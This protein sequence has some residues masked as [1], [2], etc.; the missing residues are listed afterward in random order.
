MGIITFMNTVKKFITNIRTSVISFFRGVPAGAVQAAQSRKTRYGGLSLISVAAVIGILVLLNMIVRN[1]GLRWDLT[2]NKLYS[3]SPESIRVLKDV[4]EETKA[5]VFISAS[6]PQLASQKEEIKRLLD[7]YASRNGKIKVEYVDPYRQQN[8]ATQYGITRQGTVVFVQGNRV[9]QTSNTT[10]QDFTASLIKLRNPNNTKVVFWT[11]NGEKDPEGMT[12]EGYSEV[13]ATLERLNYTVQKQ[14]IAKDATI[15]SDAGVIVLAGPRQP[16]VARHV[17][18]LTTY[19]ERGGRILVMFET[20]Q[21]FQNTGIE[22][23]LSKYGIA[24]KQGVAVDTEIYFENP[25]IPG[26]VSYP[27]HQITDKTTGKEAKDKARIVAIGDSDSGS[28]LVVQF[29]QGKQFVV[30]GNLDLIVNSINWLAA[31]EDLI[32]IV[33]KDRTQPTMSLSSQ[34]TQQ[35]QYFTLGILPGVFLL[36]AVFVWR[37]RKK[38]R[39]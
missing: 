24:V 38:L 23:L 36:L 12:D 14:D 3:L 29:S 10:E 27:Q 6:D 15:A 4:K 25:G 22:D 34:Q 37:S 32:S 35:L 11:G 7:E 31:K 17:E 16:Y 9:E 28:N 30:P 5:M 20:L 26:V 8:L 19:L 39:G 13:K 2:K 33:P 18:A 1:A 21:N